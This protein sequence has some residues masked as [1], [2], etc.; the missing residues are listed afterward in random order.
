MFDEL[1]FAASYAT[2]SIGDDLKD[3]S[4]K[5]NLVLQWQLLLTFIELG[6]VPLFDI[7]KIIPLADLIVG[8][9]QHFDLWHALDQGLQLL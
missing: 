7:G 9:V 8:Y 4:L 3:N 1:L 6:K 5:L 2:F